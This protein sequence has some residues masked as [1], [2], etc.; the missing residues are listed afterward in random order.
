MRC[1]AIQEDEPDKKLGG[2]YMVKEREKVR[3]CC[4]QGE[5]WTLEELQEYV[6]HFQ[7]KL[8][9]HHMHHYGVYGHAHFQI[10]STMLTI[11]L[12]SYRAR[13]KALQSAL[14]SLA[15]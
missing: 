3:V 10:I 11:T 6:Q 4:T 7:R 5:P 15:P 8:V 14:Q 13:V 12:E 9:H 1:Q 2:P